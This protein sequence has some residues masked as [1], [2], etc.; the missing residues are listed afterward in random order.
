[1]DYNEVLSYLYSQLPMFQ[2]VGA[3]AFKKDLTNT[4]ALC[5]VCGNPQQRFKSI[6][7]AGTNGK[8]S[9]SHMLSAILQQAGY[10]TG[11]YTSPHLKDFRERIRIN[12]EMISH[13]GVVDFVERH[14]S[15]FDRIHPSFFEMTVALCFDWFAR[16]GVEVAVIETGLGGRLDST[17]VITPDLSVIT[18]ISFDHMDMLGHTLTA[19]AGE[20]AGIIKPGIPVVIGETQPETAPVFEEKARACASAITFADQVWQVTASRPEGDRLVMDVQGPEAYDD[21]SCD[22]TGDYQLKNIPTVLAAVE[23]LVKAGYRISRDHVYAALRQVK[24]TTGLLGRWQV[25]QREP[26]IVADTGHNEAGIRYVVNQIRRQSYRQ[27]H[28]VMGVVKEKDLAPIL[29]QMP[30]EAR[31][32]F[33]RPDIPRGLD[34]SELANH[35][36]EAGLAGEVYGSVR[37]A[38][39]AARHSAGG[40]DMIFIGGST[41]VVAEAL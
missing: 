36:R 8:G 38:L 15:D 2:R 6:H 21:L 30:R 29:G 39:D 31:Y 3:S 18:N 10:R 4:L 16:N 37:E 19:I 23:A 20:K 12:G 24:D 14:R 26:L 28:V 5:E 13:K 11:L 35:A 25:L 32:Y 27:L 41:F 22:L 34:A 7:I 9:T 17:N 33:C 1:M 40:D